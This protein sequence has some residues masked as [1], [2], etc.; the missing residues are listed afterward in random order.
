MAMCHL[1]VLSRRSE[2]CPSVRGL[3]CEQRTRLGTV[4]VHKRGVRLMSRAGN[5][6]YE[7]MRSRISSAVLVQMNG[8]G[9]LFQAA[10]HL[11]S[12]FRARER[13][14]DTAAEL[15]VGE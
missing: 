6:L 10:P 15:L 14:V 12:I 7:A 3:A 1:S 13:F 8:L 11:G 4:L 2:T 5:S 9:S